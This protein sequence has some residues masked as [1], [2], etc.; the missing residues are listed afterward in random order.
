[1]IYRKYIRSKD[2][3][4]LTSSDILIN[5]WLISYG[6]HMDLMDYIVLLWAAPVILIVK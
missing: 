1:M 3:F 5:G 6:S 4:P 2:F